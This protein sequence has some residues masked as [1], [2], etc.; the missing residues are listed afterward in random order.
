MSG[1]AVLVLLALLALLLAVQA[2]TRPGS[3]VDVG[4][5]LRDRLRSREESRWAGPTR[6]R[7]VRRSYWTD[8]EYGLDS[9]RL[10]ALGYREEERQLL[11]G[12]PLP[13][14]PA[15]SQWSIARR[16]LPYAYVVWTLEPGDPAVPDVLAG[17][18]SAPAG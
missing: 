13:G 1:S 2:L 3:R 16:R 6:P 17:G 8:R 11:Q 14:F 5:R 10:T 9:A 4:S 15:D 18:D 7:V 12:A